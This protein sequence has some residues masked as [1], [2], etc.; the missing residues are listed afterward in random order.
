MDQIWIKDR[1]L[2]I[3]MDKIVV[4]NEYRQIGTGPCVGNVAT[5]FLNEFS[6]GKIPLKKPVAMYHMM[7]GSHVHVIKAILSDRLNSNIPSI[8]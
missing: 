4:D 2:G 8:L 1:A 7:H 6:T 3:K 5:V